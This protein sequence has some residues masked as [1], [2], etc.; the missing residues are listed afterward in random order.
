[1]F[2]DIMKF[3]LLPDFAVVYTDGSCLNN[4]K[5]EPRAGLGVFWGPDHP[6]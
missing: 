4:G 1:M 2:Y 5:Y 3:I 6:E